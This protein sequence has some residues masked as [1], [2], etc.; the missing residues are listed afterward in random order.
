MR[1]V[2]ARLS[3]AFFL[4]VFSVTACPQG[5]QTIEYQPEKVRHLAGVVTYT[6]GE[7]I[8]GVVV[9]DCDTDFKHVLRSVTTDASGRFSFSHVKFGSRHYLSVRFP[10]YDLD[11]HIVTI[12]HFAK[13][14]LIITLHPGT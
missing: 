8:S 13:A 10:N 7:T 14:G 6:T 9:E 2:A 4:I 5:N 11:H 12:G 3:C 1:R